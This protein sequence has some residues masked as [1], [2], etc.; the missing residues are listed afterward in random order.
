MIGGH[1]TE[2]ILGEAFYGR[3]DDDGAETGAS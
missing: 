1:A 2:L 3:R